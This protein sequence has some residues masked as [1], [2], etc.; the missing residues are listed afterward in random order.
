MIARALWKESVITAQAFDTAC[1]LR[2]FGTLIGNTDMHSGNL[3]C[4]SEGHRP[5]ELAPV[6]DMT[7]MAF[8]PTAGGRIGRL[9]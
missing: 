9:N 6:C 7:P 4:L 2:A 5:Y 8:A 3:S 1:L